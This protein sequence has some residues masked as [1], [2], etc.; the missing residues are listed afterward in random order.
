MIPEELQQIIRDLQ[1]RV[2]ALEGRV[3]ELEEEQNATIGGYNVTS[4]PAV[5]IV[6]DRLTWTATGINWAP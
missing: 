6:G 1:E 2:Q 3:K 4:P 5:P